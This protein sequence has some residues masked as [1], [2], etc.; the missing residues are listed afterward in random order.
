MAVGTGLP[1]VAAISAAGTADMDVEMR[2][3]LMTA[4]L[5]IATAL[6][7]G[8]IP[9]AAAHAGMLEDKQSGIAA[10]QRGDYAAALT[11]FT[12]ALGATGLTSNESA[13]LL[14]LRGFAY[15]QSARFAHAVSDYG[16]VLSLKP[17]A[18]EVQFR[19]AIAYRENGA[20][21]QALADLQSVIGSRSHPAPDQPFIFGERGVVRFALGQ[22][23]GAGRDFA[24]VLALDPADAYGVLWLHLARRRAGE[25]DADALAHD[26]AEATGSGW[27]APL[28]ALYLG[29]MTAAQV[30]TAAAQG[31]EDQQKEQRCEAAFFLGEDALTNGRPA[32]ARPLLQEAAAACS[33]LLSVH[34]GAIGELERIGG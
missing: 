24:R 16:A 13:D 34:A 18:T 9:I 19:R 28:L 5:L 30:E 10:S 11:L 21:A 26:A 14:L 8:L 3:R 12:R 22:F 6:L 29:A 20:Y 32:A 27:P 4:R 25:S 1:M 33:P 31:P 23:A 15:E 17:D 2:H 7:V